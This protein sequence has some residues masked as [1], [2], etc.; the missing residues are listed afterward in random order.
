MKGICCFCF[1]KHH[2]RSWMKNISDLLLKLGIHRTCLGYRYLHYI[3]QLCM[4]NEDYLLRVT[5]LYEAASKKFNTS[6]TNIESCIRNAITRCWIRGNKKY[7]I[8]IAFYDLE[9]KPSNSEFLDILYCYLSSSEDWPTFGGFLFTRL[10]FWKFLFWVLED[11]KLSINHSYETW[12][13][14]CCFVIHYCIVYC[15]VLPFHLSIPFLRSTPLILRYPIT[16][17]RVFPV[18]P[19]GCCFLRL[20]ARAAV[21]ERV[22]LAVF[23]ICF[24]FFTHASPLNRSP[25]YVVQA[26]LS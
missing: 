12:I 22:S 13:S 25:P 18:F 3:L 17:Q 19:A 10:I 23:L 1:Y 6:P 11:C 7:L 9:V 14:M 4:E 26:W 15:C 8:E 21:F 24:I 2:T 16:S 20:F 5:S